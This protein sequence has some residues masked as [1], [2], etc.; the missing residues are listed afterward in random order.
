M[1][2]GQRH[3]FLVSRR[4]RIFVDAIC[5]RQNTTYVADSGRLLFP[6][7]PILISHLPSPPLSTQPSRQYHESQDNCQEGRRKRA[8][9]RFHLRRRSL[10]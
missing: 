2:A 3:C 6:F 8:P 10:L 9:R 1:E 5:M 4:R 7:S